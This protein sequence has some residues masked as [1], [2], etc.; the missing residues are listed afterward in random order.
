M[1][2]ILLLHAVVGLGL[3]TAALVRVPRLG[4]GAMV[5]G[6]I[7]PVA[8]LAWLALHAGEVLDGD[9]VRSSLTWVAPIGLDVDLRIDGFALLV[10][11]IVSGI[12]LLVHGYAHAYFR[13]SGEGLV[14]M[15]GLLVLFAGAMLGVVAADNL[16]ILYGAWELTSITSFLLIGHAYRNASARAAALQAMLI[17]GA[18]GLAMLLGF[19]I[20]GVQAGTFS[21]TALLADPP[22]GTAVDVALVLVLLGAVTKS[23]QYPFHSWLPGAM[24]APTPTSAYLHSA[25]MVKAG[26]ILVARFAPAFGDTSA[27]WRPT[28]LAIGLVTMVAGALRA[29]RQ[30]DLKLLLAF[31]T[32]SQLGFLFVLFGAGTP[33]M[34]AAGCAVLLAHATFK[35]TLFMVVGIVDRGAGTRDLRV[36]PPLPGRRWLAVKVTAVVAAASMAGI[37]LTFGFIAKEAGLA[38]IGY[39]DIGGAALVLAIVVVGS[40][41]TAAYAAR[42]VAGVLGASL[43]DRAAGT[44]PAPAPALEFVVPGALLA[45]LIVVTGLVPGLLDATMDAAARSLV[46]TVAPVHLALWHGLN[47]PL[48]LSAVAIGAGAVLHLRSRQLAP[49]LARGARLPSGQAGYQAFLR[50]LTSSAERVTGVVQSGSMPV[51]LGV[52]L[53]TAALLPASAL[54]AVDAWGGWPT[55]VDSWAQVPVVIILIAAA[56]GAAV[57]RHRLS[58]ALLLGTCGYAMVALFVI[59]GAPDLAL[60]QAGVETLTTVLFV[61]ALRQLPQRFDTAALRSTQALRIGIALIV[62]CT[63]FGFTLLAGDVRLPRDVSTEMVERSLPDGNGRN[64]VN[65]ILVDFRGLD[66]LGEITVLAVGS[67]GAVAL[68]RAGRRPRRAAERSAQ[69]PGGTTRH[70][71]VEVVL[72]T[73]VHIA[74]MVS[75]FLLV[76]GHNQPGGGFV[77]GLVA[78]AAVALRYVSGGLDEVRTM[79][80]AQP[81]TLLGAGVLLAATTALVPVALGRPLLDN[82]YA[83][84]PFPGLGDLSVSSALA[85]DLGVYLVVVGLVFMV[86]EAFGDDDPE[87]VAP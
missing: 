59:Q 71:F 22:S 69:G 7:A 40:A 66:T 37:P 38:A 3:L 1:G 42:F 11:A 41:L 63:V 54:I 61:L 23:A 10:A 82:A 83:S 21:M 27:L 20:L 75:L 30:H 6:A 26:V 9:V 58:A 87:P 33:E 73:L 35:A 47:L 64:V 28:V 84:F 62:A 31:G 34:T 15:A 45:A 77:G 53:L 56:I 25:T 60:T 12:G 52:I 78:G 68:A 72:R 4:R 8:T 43:D 48:L 44:G 86:F 81:W 24:A 67:I 46:P 74:W 36:L 16:I 85:F 29:L 80:R 49:L 18:G 51:Y 76:M 19:V 2:A 79:V 50:G 65:V 17:T 5:V 55:L 13:S 32:V 57:V 70:Q 14:R 39:D